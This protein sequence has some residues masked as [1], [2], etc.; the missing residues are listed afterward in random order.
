MTRRVTIAGV[1]LAAALLFAGV[2]IAAV[3]TPVGRDV[4]GATSVPEIDIT[5]RELAPREAPKPVRREPSGNP[6]WGIPLSGL[7]ATR[8]RP[9]FLPSRRPPAPVVAGPP[10]VEPPKP[11]A[12]VVPQ[13]PQ[14]TFVGAVLGDPDKIA[15]FLDASNN[16]VRLHLGQAHAGWVLNAVK[17]REATL[18]KDSETAVFVLPASGSPPPAA[19]PNIPGLP[20][21]APRTGS[22]APEQVV[23]PTGNQNFFPFVPR[24]PP[25]NGESDGL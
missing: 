20:Q 9:I 17:N 8:E 19:I 13:R 6:L 5:P 23:S 18:Q 3:D 12:P 14:L 21:S 22:A 16:A 7:T 15:V 24:H 10:P 11:P 25:K 2:V 4:P 1:G